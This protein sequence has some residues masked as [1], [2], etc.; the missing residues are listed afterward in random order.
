MQKKAENACSTV[1]F[2][3]SYKKR[4]KRKHMFLDFFAFISPLSAK[5]VG[6]VYHAD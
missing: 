3:N 1:Q 2:Q 6:G 4:Q 5:K